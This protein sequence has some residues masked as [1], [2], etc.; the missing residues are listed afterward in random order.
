MFVTNNLFGSNHQRNSTHLLQF[1]ANDLDKKMYSF[2]L[3]ACATALA[4]SQ[5]KG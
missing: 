2:I 4:A 5:R 3:A 1:A